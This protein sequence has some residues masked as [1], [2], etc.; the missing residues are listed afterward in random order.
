MDEPNSQFKSYL[1]IF[2]NPCDVT[3]VIHIS[4]STDQ[5]LFICNEHRNLAFHKCTNF[6]VGN[7]G[8][9]KNYLESEELARQVDI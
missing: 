5:L 3:Y 4:N 7:S 8:E 1:C 9:Q 6:K 2:I